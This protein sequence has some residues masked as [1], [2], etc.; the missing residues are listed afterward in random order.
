M[1]DYELVFD[2]VTEEFNNDMFGLY[3]NS[4]SRADFQQKLM[5]DGWKYFDFF[6][7]NEL[8]AI[9]Y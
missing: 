9:K 1:D 3:S 6:N 7:L 2:E 8:F 5:A 4:V